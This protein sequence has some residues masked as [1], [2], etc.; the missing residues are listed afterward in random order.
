MTLLDVL[1][2]DLIKVPLTSVD[3]RS[4]IEELVEVYRKQSGISSTEAGDIVNAVLNREAQASTAMENG[5]A[6]PHAK[7]ENIKKSVVVI[8][9]SRLGVDFGGDEGSKVFFLVLAPKDNPTEHIQLLASI[10]KVCS[11]NLYSRMLANAKNNDDVYQLFF[12]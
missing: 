5:I 9:V 8:G 10:A 4:V 12:D 3:R 2:K 11:S 7:L 6:I 1:N